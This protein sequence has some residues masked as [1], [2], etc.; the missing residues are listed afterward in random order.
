MAVY[1][2]IE[3]LS[4]A[5]KTV[6][7]ERVAE[8]L[9][10][11]VRAIDSLKTFGEQIWS[12]EFGVRRDDKLSKFLYDLSL[13]RG[14]IDYTKEPFVFSDNFY[15]LMWTK[16]RDNLGADKALSL[17]QQALPAPVASI[18]LHVPAQERHLRQFRRGADRLYRIDDI[19][20]STE[21]NRDE[22]DFME[23][24]RWLSE[25]IPYIYVLD[26]TQSVESITDKIVEIVYDNWHT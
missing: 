15:R 3:G 6:Q 11:Q 9:G 1:V 21:M 4:G 20:I 2:T 24:F 5:G 8:A 18:C 10:W 25:R 19:K 22:D 13:I 17:F 12:M 26:G 14:Y 7:A 16:Y 23:F